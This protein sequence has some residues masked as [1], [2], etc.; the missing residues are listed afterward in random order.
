MVVVATDGDEDAVAAQ[1]DRV[2][3]LVGKRVFGDLTLSD[4]HVKRHRTS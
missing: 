1:D 3:V 2:K 4:E